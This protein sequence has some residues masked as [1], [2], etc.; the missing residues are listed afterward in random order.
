MKV[1][2]TGGAG[3]I[4]ANLCRTLLAD[5]NV[6]EVRVIDD[7]S[8]G[9]AANLAGVDVEFVEASI[10]DEDALGAIMSG[11]DGVAHLAAVPSVP[12]SIAEPQ[13][14]HAA[15][16]TGTLLV[17]EAARRHAGHVVVASSS[18]V[19]GSTPGLPK[20]ED[21]A[22]R[23]MSPYAA[24]KL[25]TE[26]YALAYA[27]SF[28]LPTLP[29]RFFNV[30]GPLQPA[31]HAY[32]A[33][34]PIFIDAALAGRPL[35]IQGDGMQSRDFTFVDTV[36]GVITDALVRR[37]SSPVPVNLALGTNIDLLGLID[38]LEQVIGRPLEREFGEP[39]RGDVRAS[40]ADSTRL[41]ELF[42]DAPVVPLVDGV[43]RTVDWFT[44]TAG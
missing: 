42:P 17:L 14:S 25:A 5:P 7:L 28:D 24:S 43:Q 23:P 12:R 32:A 31:G 22:T 44:Q 38:V 36:T 1:L 27:S 19:Y 6:T 40:Q 3:F 35:P 29:F 4:G 11:V 21:M 34:I 10:L 15:N 2:V 8:T 20:S 26:S 16:A 30:Y 9:S 37:V 41:R 13:R 18:S 33:V 39:R